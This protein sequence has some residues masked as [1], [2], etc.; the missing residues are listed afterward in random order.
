MKRAQEFSE[1]IDLS[2]GQVA[3]DL[4][5]MSLPGPE[6]LQVTVGLRYNSLIQEAVKN[7][8][9][10]HPTGV[11]GLGWS[12]PR[13]LILT[14]KGEGI[15]SGET[16][17]LLLHQDVASDLVFSTS[18]PDGSQT[19][20]AA[21]QPN[22][23][24]NYFPQNETW[25]VINQLGIKLSFGGSQGT[26][27]MLAIDDWLASSTQTSLMRQVATAWNLLSVTDL[28]GNQTLYQYDMIMNSISGSGPT[29]TQSSYLKTITNAWGDRIELTY[30]E[31]NP[32][33]YQDP[34]S[35]SGYQAFYETKALDSFI[36]T[37]KGSAGALITAQLNYDL[38]FIT[39]DGQNKDFTKRLLQNVTWTYGTEYQHTKQSLPPLIFGYATDLQSDVNPGALTT[40][41]TLEGSI[42]TYTY[43]KAG[44]TNGV[45]QYSQREIP[46]PPPTKTGVTFGHP[47]FIFEDNFTV[48]LWIGS[49]NSLVFQPYRWQGR[50]LAGP[51]ITVANGV[52]SG[53]D[54]ILT[55]SHDS[56]FSLLVQNKI[57]LFSPDP[58]SP[59]AW[60]SNGANGTDVPNP[61][62]NTGYNLVYGERFV[63]LLCLPTGDLY[64]YDLSNL[65]W[66]TEQK[67]TT[68]LTHQVAFSLS[69]E[70]NKILLSSV[71]SSSLSAWL[72]TRNSEGIWQTSELKKNV[73]LGTS[74]ALKS[75]LGSASIAILAGGKAGP[76]EFMTCYGGALNNEGHLTKLTDLSSTFGS[77]N[78]T[79]FTVI[80]MTIQAGNLMWRFNGQT[81]MEADLSSLGLAAGDVVNAVQV[82]PDTATRT[83]TLAN[84]KHHYDLVTYSAESGTWAVRSTAAAPGNGVGIAVTALSKGIP[85]RYTALADSLYYMSPDL[86]WAIVSGGMPPTL[87]AADAPSVTLLNSQYLLYQVTGHSQ[88]ETKAIFLGNGKTKGAVF[89]STGSL[90]VTGKPSHDLIGSQA[91]VTYTGDWSGAQLVLTLHRLVKEN[92]KGGQ[93]ALVASK[94]EITSGYTGTNVTLPDGQTSDQVTL[95]G[96]MTTSMA[97]DVKGAILSI[98][99]D[100]PAFNHVT[101]YPGSATPT[102]SN[103]GTTDIYLFN[104]LSPGESPV[105]AP[106]VAANITNGDTAPSLLAGQIY[107]TID[108]IFKNQTTT[109]QSRTD[110]Y[111]WATLTPLKNGWSATVRNKR[112]V[113]T[114]EG[115]SK[116]ENMTYSADTSQLSTYETSRINEAGKVITI[117]TALTY[118]WQQ[119]DTT[120]STN[121]LDA[122]IEEIQTAKVGAGTP[123][124]IAGTVTTWHKGWDNDVW[125]CDRSYRMISANAVDFNAWAAGGTTPT[126]WQETNIINSYS[127]TGLV[128][129]STDISGIISLNIP[130]K[131]GRFICASAHNANSSRFSFYGFEPY[132]DPNGWVSTSG[133]SLNRFI[134]AAD[135][136]TGSSCLRVPKGTPDGTV[137]RLFIPD[138]LT[139]DYVFS[140]WTRTPPGFDKGQGEANFTGEIYWTENKTQKSAPLSPLTL[141]TAE[142]A[143]TYLQTLI[144]INAVLSGKSPDAGSVSIFFKIKNANTVD[145]ILV[146]ELRL[147]PLQSTML[148]SVLDD[149]K[150]IPLAQIDTNGQSIRTMYNDFLQ[151]IVTMG[152]DGEILTAEF[153]GLSRQLSRTND[154][155]EEKTPN[156]T[157]T[158]TPGGLTQYDDFHGD[159]TSNWNLT[160][161]TSGSWAIANGKLAYSGG[162]KGGLGAIAQPKVPSN[163][164]FAIHIEAN[165]GSGAT[166][167]IGDGTI[168]LSWN[169]DNHDGKGGFSLIEKDGQNNLTSLQVAP[170]D[171]PFNN[172]WMFSVVDGF[173]L[174]TVNELPIFTYDAG[175]SPATGNLTLAV[176]IGG[177]FDKLIRLDDPRLN[178]SFKDGLLRETQNLSLLG[179]PATGQTA[180]KITFMN[181]GDFSDE[182]G[183]SVISKSPMRAILELT[184]AA[185]PK[186]PELPDGSLESYLDNTDGTALSLP[187][188]IATGVTVP[189]MGPQ[190]T[191]NMSRYEASPLGRPIEIIRGR[192][193]SNTDAMGYISSFIYNGISALPGMKATK[194]TANPA[195][196][197][198][199]ETVQ[200]GRETVT[201]T[202]T[203]ITLVKG[204][205]RDTDGN[206]LETYAGPENAPQSLRQ[207][208]TYDAVGRLLS[209]QQANG[210][211]PPTGTT[212]ANWTETYAYDFLGRRTRKTSP[213]SGEVL[214]AYDQTD[215]LRFI[216]DSEGAVAKVNNVTV[217]RIK[218][219]RYDILGRPIESGWIQDANFQW[220]S[221]ALLAQI[222]NQNFPKITGGSGTGPSATGRWRQSDHY[223]TDGQAASSYYL[224]RLYQTKTQ[225]DSG[226]EVT[227]EN[228]TY[229]SFGR[230]LSTSISIAGA[231]AANTEYVFSPSGDIASITYPSLGGKSYSVGYYYD[232]MG[233]IAGIG[234]KTNAYDIVDP[235]KPID[236]IES[237]YSAYTYGFLGELIAIDFNRPPSSTNPGF[238]RQMS[239]DDEGRVKGLK[240]P[241]L[242]ID[243]SYSTP[244]KN[245]ST[246]QIGSLSTDY[247]FSEHW[248]TPPLAQAYDYQYDPLGR[249]ITATDAHNSGL[250]F[251]SP[252]TGSPKGYDPNGNRHAKVKGLTEYNYAYP[253]GAEVGKPGTPANGYSSLTP[254][255]NSSEDFSS[256]N[257]HQAGAWKWG[258]NNGGPSSSQITTTNPHSGTQCLM[259]GGGNILG[260]SETLSL[261]TYFSPDATLSLDVY[262][263]TG[264]GYAAKPNNQAQWSLGLYGPF[265]LVAQKALEFVPVGTAWTKQNITINIPA[266]LT[267]MG[268]TGQITLVDLS[269]N[270]RTKGTTEGSAGAE[271][272]VDDIGL[273]WPSPPTWN[274]AYNKN[275]NMT[276]LPDKHLTV[277]Y[278]HNLNRAVSASRTDYGSLTSLYDSEGRVIQKT[279][280]LPDHSTATIDFH[281]DLAGQ[282]LAKT[283][284]R[285][286]NTTVSY[287]VHGPDG[288]IA[289]DFGDD[290]I[291]TLKDHSG[292]TRALIDGATNTVVGSFD[293]LPFGG[294]SRASGDLSTLARYTN[295]Q[296]N[297]VTGLIDTPA[298]LYDQDNGRFLQIDPKNDGLSPY[299]YCWNDPINLTDPDGEQAIAK[300]I[301]TLVTAGSI[302]YNMYKLWGAYEKFEEDPVEFAYVAAAT[303]VG[304]AVPYAAPRSIPFIASGLSKI[305]VG[306]NTLFHNFLSIPGCI[307]V[308]TFV[309]QAGTFLIQ[310]EV[311]SFSYLGLKWSF[312]SNRTIGINHDT[313]KQWEGAVSTYASE[314]F[315][316]NLG[317]EA[318]YS[319]GYGPNRIGN[320]LSIHQNPTHPNLPVFFPANLNPSFDEYATG[321]YWLYPWSLE[322][323]R[324]MRGDVN[325]VAA[326]HNE[327]FNYDHLRG[328]QET[329]Q[330]DLYSDFATIVDRRSHTTRYGGPPHAGSSTF[331]RRGL[332]TG[333]AAYNMATNWASLILSFEE[334][335]KLVKLYNALLGGQESNHKEL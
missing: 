200:V 30:I 128:I 52:T 231:T 160:N 8:N 284:T 150:H 255:T 325:R 67:I 224:N 46:L 297:P 300:T 319:S 320:Y 303:A 58:K 273:T 106:P 60:I 124:K 283:E 274:S 309:R 11:A 18:N 157:L 162:T 184:S 250:G 195:Y 83:I 152:P 27:Y 61:N 71:N 288:L 246:S 212:A 122:V 167:S 148:V 307:P 51:E 41:T 141:S 64:R 264:N 25:V 23:K 26:E 22:W 119:Y 6:T 14:Q 203:P 323:N 262:T 16:S 28:F 94:V 240:D 147:S 290:P 74:L 78:S 154:L 19:W 103:G 121:I 294:L 136:H 36:Y 223:D 35:V 99:G 115:V 329:L 266:I 50:W 298:R 213:D 209:K 34:Y 292:S 192:P 202:P 296:I 238:S 177:N 256:A 305:L 153:S 75:S 96:S 236:W 86:N 63:C 253:T 164:N 126:G 312:S 275:G 314:N 248:K 258:S 89:S 55:A 69:T 112:I 165:P 32:D 59:E 47:K 308:T 155:F 315:G 199:Q 129:Q 190:F 146:D 20:I 201:E 149:I 132:E 302:T 206:L 138:D 334:T 229:D 280:T 259:L 233:R 15:S 243:I 168:F 33:E 291:F 230:T 313:W 218:Y 242:N 301:M 277:Q 321:F 108:S 85:S 331:I 5:L 163:K 87:T 7:W 101:S 261:E 65:I 204:E 84:G 156:T 186:S 183:R 235:G 118:F 276:G 68:G 90:L 105:L 194:L 263:R 226:N 328:N 29:Y 198:K 269:L 196:F 237:R 244:N 151:P 170:P 49:D 193:T 279:E 254:K 145:Q 304:I 271:I 104:N 286:G 267:E 211:A 330:H 176:D 80:A 142:T 10:T 117:T 188:F 295:H 82:G 179:R 53:Y 39:G 159:T 97:F 133:G 131:E 166:M 205:I 134:T 114:L 76:N 217:Q 270:N 98:T 222:D 257:G 241:Y 174:C 140:C 24:I 17:Y 210:A 56:G 95:A 123:E 178:L 281:Y 214:T 43:E 93:S 72:A 268:L 332:A 143:W 252:A 9:L 181:G 40:V 81:W 221:P 2:T 116:T 232:R 110:K 306:S 207:K 113:S 38:S 287:Y 48:V 249:L 234:Q 216:M 335:P 180:G 317:L 12:L 88:T 130:D 92:I 208:S 282:L 251:A 260:H 73:Q 111:W 227:L 4:P 293:Y 322:G 182:I 21:T 127:D 100:T 91:F 125:A 219:I 324:N 135:S 45:L 77:V 327:V 54:G 187:T 175:S 311:S 66:S 37:P 109:P 197:E 171:V 318:V 44:G 247:H 316:W 137:G 333:L 239:Y 299:A 189:E 120:R 278:D 107:T 185:A 79:T 326:S 13:S 285:K 289:T 169:P 272:Y 161:G 265:G 102:P 173:Y 62:G 158:L 3:F 215:K 1:A 42:V 310:Q 245:Y 220:G 31:K 225:P 191:Y 144:D 70:R 57:F 228:Q 172:N 139:Q